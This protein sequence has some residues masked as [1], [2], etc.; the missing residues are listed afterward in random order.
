MSSRCPEL[1]ALA[2]ACALAATPAAARELRVCADPDNLPFS[3]AD[4]SGF[5]NRIATLVASEMRAD[6]R[7]YWLPDRRGFARKT[8]GA[9]QCDVIVGVPAPAERLLTTDPYY[10]GAYM[11]VYRSRWLKRLAS[12][13]DPRL[14]SLR[15]G[16]ALIGNDLA[17]TPPAHALARRGIVANVVGFPVVG[18]RP[19][20]ER[21]IEALGQG[22]IDV[23]V[24]WGP[25]AGYFAKR[26]PMPIALTEVPQDGTGP[27]EF[28]IAM[29]VRRDDPALR[30]ELDGAL[31]RARR[32]IDGVLAEYAVPRADRAPERVR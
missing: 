13:D 30:D 27:V 10:R 29:G 4:G 3:R 6:L 8:L 2:L 26:A 28:D 21:M 5:E 16:V 31:A 18:D 15:I 25:Q 19:V 20:G 17:A 14:R 22:R 11:F 12:Y 9:G 23:A 1:A 24:L 32:A 7:Y